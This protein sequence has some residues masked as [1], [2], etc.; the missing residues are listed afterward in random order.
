MHAVGKIENQGDADDVNDKVEASFHLPHPGKFSYR[1]TLYKKISPLAKNQSTF[2][3]WR[4]S[5]ILDIF[6]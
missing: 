2:Q 5:A 6:R 3:I 1:I 4:R